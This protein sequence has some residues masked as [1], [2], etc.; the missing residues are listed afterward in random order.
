[1]LWVLIWVLTPELVSQ[2]GSRVEINIAAQYTGAELLK[3]TTC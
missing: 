1:M 3:G 2:M